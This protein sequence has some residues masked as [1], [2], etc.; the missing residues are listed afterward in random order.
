MTQIAS[1]TRYREDATN[2]EID[3]IQAQCLA[4]LG[5]QISKYLLN[6]PVRIRVATEIKHIEPWDIEYTLRATIDPA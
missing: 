1:Q 3:R 2:A 5:I 6:G 4:Y